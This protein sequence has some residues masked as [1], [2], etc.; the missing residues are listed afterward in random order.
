MK[1][2]RLKPRITGGQRRKLGAAL[3]LLS[4][5][6]TRPLYRLP[7]SL[8]SA[9][10]LS[11]SKRWTTPAKNNG[12]TWPGW[13]PQW[14]QTRRSK[15]GRQD[16]GEAEDKSSKSKESLP[17]SYSA[18]PVQSSTS[19]D[20][21]AQA[22]LDAFR[23]V[24]QEGRAEV[25]EVLQPFL[26]DPEREDLKSQQKKLNRLRSIKSKIQ[27]KER[28]Q[29]KDEQQWY[30]WLDEV[31]SLIEAQKTQHEETQTRL[32]KEINELKV[33][34]EKLKQQKDQECMEVSEE[35]TKEEQVQGLL[36]ELTA[37]RDKNV[38]EKPKMHAVQQEQD[39][40]Q[41]LL[42]MQA[43]L[44]L[45]FQ[46]K[47]HAAQQDMEQRYRQQLQEDRQQL[48]QALANQN[49]T[50]VIN[51]VDELD[52]LDGIS[53]PTKQK[54]AAQKG[55]GAERGRSK[56][57]LSPYRKE[58]VPAQTMQERLQQSHGGTDPQAKVEQKRE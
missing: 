38:V 43:Q 19:E 30:K 6:H 11:M 24:V 18:V 2:L 56:T 58:E 29:A 57:A 40:E 20:Q 47:M 7:T 33:E 36:D 41:K 46:Q 52:G 14:P 16:K 5:H 32:A 25:P 37:P 55:Y 15:G 51:L 31:K 17:L 23:K 8:T 26:P 54:D 53:D 10:S 22:F 21:G 39:I 1:R 9:T 42:A 49:T 45:D 13:S 34:E 35:E 44:Q 48:Q 28:A 3:E 27:G 12:N 4:S 50:Q